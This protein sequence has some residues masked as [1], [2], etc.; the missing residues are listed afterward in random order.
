[1]F[2]KQ[3][4]VTT[5]KNNQIGSLPQR[6]WDALFSSSWLK[7]EIKME[8]KKYLETKWYENTIYW[9]LDNATKER[10]QRTFIAKKGMKEKERVEN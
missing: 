3:N 6:V 8:I 1:M 2:K 5:N 9:N 4:K 7:Q 10:L